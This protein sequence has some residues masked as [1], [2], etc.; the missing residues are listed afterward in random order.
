MWSGGTPP[1]NCYINDSD[2]FAFADLDPDAKGLFVRNFLFNYNLP[3]GSYYFWVTRG[4]VGVDE[5]APTPVGVGVVFR[6]SITSVYSRGYEFHI[7]FSVG[8]GKKADFYSSTT[9]NF[10]SASYIGSSGVDDSTFDSSGF[11]D[12]GSVYFFWMVESS[13]SGDVFSLPSA[14][15][16]NKLVPEVTGFYAN[17]VAD[18]T[19]GI[20]W[21]SGNDGEL[22]RDGNVIR[23]DDDGNDIYFDD[24]VTNFEDHAY[25][26]RFLSDFDGT[27]FNSWGP[28]SGPIIAYATYGP[29][30]LPPG[31]TTSIG[32]SIVR[33]VSNYLWG[34]NNS[35]QAGTRIEVPFVD[36]Y[37]YGGNN[38]WVRES[39]GGIGNEDVIVESTIVNAVN[40]TDSPLSIWNGKP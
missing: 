24:S 25:T 29:V 22:R 5:S 17:G 26:I 39:D 36:N 16:S 6:P 15:S 23:I 11:F 37:T 31:S 12:Q 18:G 38:I 28:T 14:S 34:A 20:S 9:D 40:S 4:T 27:Q 33:R 2:D 7:S 1:F 21:D 8:S 35:I 13:P 3:V 30:T 10:D 19:I 32:Q